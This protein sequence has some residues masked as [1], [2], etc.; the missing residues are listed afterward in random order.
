MKFGRLAP[1]VAVAAALVSAC[2]PDTSKLPLP[3][4]PGSATGYDVVLVTLDTTRADHLGSY[5]DEEANTPVLDR[6]AREGVRFETAISPAPLTLPA[7]ASILTGLDPPSH[8]VR[9][10]GQFR[11]AEEQ[12]TLA[13]RLRAEGYQTAAFV[14]SFVLDRRYGLAQGFDTYDDRV[15][16]SPDASFGGIENER[17]GEAVTDA[18]L[19]WLKETKERSGSTPF[20]LWVHYY[21]A[22]YPYDPPT[23]GGRARMTARSR[24]STVRSGGSS[25]AS[26]RS[27]TRNWS[28]SSEIMER[29]S[30]STKKRPIL[31]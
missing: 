5:G 26:R 30:E 8:G 19:A 29:A 14:G 23:G 10:N 17:K 27:T 22:H 28:S 2:G 25:R 7:H 11:L 1:L 16:A 4:A 24:T 6:L 12:E 3:V 13:E 20:F 15:D 21:D 31:V 9:H 18:A